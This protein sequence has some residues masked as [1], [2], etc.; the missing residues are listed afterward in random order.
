[1]EQAKPFVISKQEVW[2]AY[3]Q[4][5]V[6]RGAAGVDGETIAQF[7]RDLKKNLYRLW[8]RLSSGSYLPCPVR[9]VEIP[10]SDGKLRPLGIPTVVDRIAQTVVKNMLEP[11][12]EA[13][14][15]R[16]SYGYRPHRSAHQ[17]VGSAR[18]R[19]RYMDWVV[20][21]D[22]KGFFDNLDHALLM[23]AVRKHTD[24]RWV[25]LYIERWLTAP[26]Q[27]P[28]GT[29]VVNAGKGTPQG[30]VISQLLANLF[31]HYAFD[32]WMDKRFPD[33]PFERYAD[34]VICHCFSKAQ[35]DMLL[36][37][38]QKRLAECKLELHPDK[39]KIVYCKDEARRGR[40]PVTKFVFLGYEFRPR[41]VRNSQR[42]TV[43]ARFTPAVSPK[44]C[45]TMRQMIRSWRLHLK[46][47]LSLEDV[48]KQIRPILTGWVQY[49]GHFNRALLI[50]ALGTVDQYLVRWAMRK[51]KRL[52]DKYVQG[53]QW[54]NGLRARQPGLF[55]T[56]LPSRG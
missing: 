20:D 55:P 6:N 14:F 9:R 29:L 32:R 25:L 38:V 16:D 45:K 1:M 19:C 40:Y 36:R 43:F 31:L 2:Q 54:L 11:Q 24:C 30:G 4:V 34:D 51:Y 42:G 52:R 33:L 23:K 50:N 10:K 27:M 47:T 26:V 21:L 22:I 13:V 5:K 41:W 44:A 35:A 28:D 37:A 7:E 15:H 56:W 48:V 17:A 46:T 8:N 3:K 12:L 49:Y 39:T 53:W 18:Q